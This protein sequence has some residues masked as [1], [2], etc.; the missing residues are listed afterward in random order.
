MRDNL[1]GVIRPTDFEYGEDGFVKGKLVAK[2]LRL[3]AEA[4][5]D[6]ETLNVDTAFLG[7]D[8]YPFHIALH[9]DRAW[10]LGESV[11]RD[12]ARELIDG[13]YVHP[14]TASWA[15]SETRSTDPLLNVLAICSHDIHH[16]GFYRNM[17]VT[18]RRSLEARY[19]E[20]FL[21]GDEK[22]TAPFEKHMETAKRYRLR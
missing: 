15:R 10:R 1:D 4:R 8:I 11:A 17:P 12:Y 20:L 16:L 19:P 14:D 18:M 6:N 3:S 9:L 13:G 21:E 2:A 5:R 7:N 22:L